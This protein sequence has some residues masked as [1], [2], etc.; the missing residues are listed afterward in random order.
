M[1]QIT[2]VRFWKDVGFQDGAIE[3]PSVNDHLPKPDAEFEESIKTSTSEF[4]S[5]F[6]IPEVFANYLSMSY[7]GLEYE[8]NNSDTPMVFYGWID[9]I[10]LKSD[11]DGNPSIT[12]SWHID[13]WR[14]YLSNARF[15]YGLV[16]NRPRA[17]DDPPQLC[18]ARYREPHGFQS[19]EYQGVGKESYWIIATY[20][21]ENDDSKVTDVRTMV[22]PVNKGDPTNSRYMK[23]DPTSTAY[24]CPSLYQFVNGRWTEAFGIAPSSVSSVFISP[25]PPL[26]IYSGTGTATDPYVVLKSASSSEEYYSERGGQYAPAHGVSFKVTTGSTWGFT[27]TWT[28]H[29]VNHSATSNYGG[30]A[31]A[32]YIAREYGVGFAKHVSSPSS[33]T[34]TFAPEISGDEYT[35]IFTLDDLIR[36][37]IG[38]S[39]WNGL[40]DGDIFRI[41]GSIRYGADLALDISTSG[42]TASEA[43]IRIGVAGYSTAV[44]GSNHEFRYSKGNNTF[45]NYKVLVRTE[46]TDWTLFTKQST[47]WFDYEMNEV[48]D[49]C[50]IYTQNGHYFEYSQ[51]LPDTFAWDDE[52]QTKVPIMTTDTVEWM[53]TDQTGVPVGTLPWGLKLK[54]YN[55]RNVISSTACYI[56]YRFDGIDSHVKGTSFIVPLPTIDIVSNSW[57]EYVYSGQRDYDIQQRKLAS[58]QALTSGIVSALTGGIDTAVMGALTNTSTTTNEK[59]S[60]AYGKESASEIVEGTTVTRGIGGIKAGVVGIGAGV[61]GAGANYLIAQYYNGQLQK[62]ED[63]LSAK[64]V[65]SVMMAGN[66]WDWMWNGREFGLVPMRG[67][68]YSVNRFEND[69]RLNGVRVSE[70]TEDCDAYRTQ[71][72]PVRIAELIVTGDIP[73]QA[74]AYIKGRLANGVRIRTINTQ[75]VT[76]G[77]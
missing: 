24:K 75:T 31:I 42:T 28:D 64:Q 65:D 4:F 27:A 45:G 52:A 22:V 11:T 19:M 37:C 26:A 51:D 8:Y 21:V 55:I 38:D 16:Q 63:I 29:T 5:A 69:I 68:T 33:T 57:S 3:V 34:L 23:K 54:T 14:T 61:V 7:I 77:D 39:V 30:F 1:S 44:E 56:E 9:D 66:G 47:D 58:E 20:T 46:K 41:N 60:Y 36:N 72:G 73:V 32:T 18:T 49:K 25:I 76:E 10:A 74:R 53:F 12:V 35:Y 17:S 13:H 43:V 2:K 71:E 70:P 67:D 59:R 48:D 15:G 40:K 50:Y 62:A 6:T